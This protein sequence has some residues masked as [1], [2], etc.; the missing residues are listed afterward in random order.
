MTVDD[1]ISFVC[2]VPADC[3][4]PRRRAELHAAANTGSAYVTRVVEG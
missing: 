2:A 1:K 4:A 3:P